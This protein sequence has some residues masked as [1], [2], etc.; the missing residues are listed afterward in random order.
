VSFV[1]VC[2]CVHVCVCVCVWVYVSTCRHVC[3]RVCMAVYLCAYA[4]YGTAVSSE[5]ANFTSSPAIPCPL[6]CSSPA[7]EQ[8]G[9]ARSARV[10][11][12]HSCHAG[13]YTAYPVS[14]LRLLLAALSVVCHHPVLCCAMSCC[15][16]L[17]C[18]V[19]LCCAVLY[20]VLCCVV[21]YAVLCCLLSWTCETTHA[22]PPA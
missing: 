22:L 17:C 6:R 13:T 7:C 19:L 15:A 9:H 3:R 11:S 16:V 10:S 5:L 18:T 14:L 4:A 2:V 1:W 20:V 21:L 12:A 8:A